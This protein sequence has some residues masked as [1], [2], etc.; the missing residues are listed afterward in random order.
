MSAMQG[1]L[2]P[3]LRSGKHTVMPPRIGDTGQGSWAAGGSVG[4]GDSLLG[5]V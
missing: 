2:W 1:V 5:L 4:S 3:L